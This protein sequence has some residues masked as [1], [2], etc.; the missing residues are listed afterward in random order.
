MEP[1]PAGVRLDRGHQVHVPKEAP[2][3]SGQALEGQ[4][5]EGEDGQGDEGEEGG[6]EVVEGEGLEALLGVAAAGS[7]TP[8]PPVPL[9]DPRVT[10]THQTARTKKGNCKDNGREKTDG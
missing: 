10:Q 5:E 9:E 8:P 2:A 4:R 3:T 6:H 7:R 1:R